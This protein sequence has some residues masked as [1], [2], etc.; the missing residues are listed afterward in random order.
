M[1]QIIVRILPISEVKNNEDFFLSHVTKERKEKA[2]AMLD[3]E[4]RY[5]S[6]GAGY[7]INK[8]TPSEE[9]FYNKEHKP[10]K[11]SCFFNVSHSFDYVVFLKS[12]HPCGIDI[13][14]VIDMKKKLIPYAFSEEEQKKINSDNDFFYLWTLKEALVKAQGQGFAAMKSKDVPSKEGEILYL[15]RKYYLKSIN[16]ND[17]RISLCIEDEPIDSIEIIEEH[18]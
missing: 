9:V 2:L 6:L 10:F 5:Q 8:Y 14:K 1:N 13:E 7:L 4:R 3:E 15:G 12:Q 16:Y 11:K 18:I 17:Y